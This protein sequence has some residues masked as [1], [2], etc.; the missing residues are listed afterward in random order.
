LSTERAI[1]DR[2]V[3]ALKDA[4][5]YHIKIISA[6]TSGHP[7]C[8]ACIKGKFVSF[9]FKSDTG[10]VS[11]LQ[12]Y[13]HDQIRQSGGIVFVVNSKNIQTV[14]DFIRRINADN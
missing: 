11:P 5:I 1:Q 9:E 14:I 12:K 7:D 13:R 6:S 2:F 10:R 8:I 4:G 3:K